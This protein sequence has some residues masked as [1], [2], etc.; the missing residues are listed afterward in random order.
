[1]HSDQIDISLDVVRQLIDEQ[2]RRWRSLPIRQVAVSGT[3]NALFRIGDHLGARFPLRSADLAS[4]RREIEREVEAAQTLLG[5][6]PFPTPEPVAFGEPGFGYPL[7]WSVQT[8]LPGTTANDTDPG[9]SLPFARDLAAFIRAV[10][11]IDTGDRIFSGSGRGGD[12]RDHDEWMDT[13]FKRSEHLL[14]V[15]VRRRM[16]T[17][18]RDLPQPSSD[19]V[20]TH[21]DLIPGNVLVAQGRLTGI[22]DVGGLGPADPALDLVCAWHLLDD[23]PRKILREDLRCDDIEWERGKAWAFEQSLGAAWYYVDTNPGMSQ[24]GVRTLERLMANTPI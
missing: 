18:F 20:M 19:D 14:D 15:P 9:G 2:F 17:A 22:L 6:T 7:P 23:A 3:V 1:M 8:W 11:A 5:R 21:G 13:C 10:R 24:M 12:L 16:W 4:T